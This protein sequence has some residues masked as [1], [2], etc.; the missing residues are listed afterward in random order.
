MISLRYHIV[1]I[2]AV[3]LAIAIGL[4]A[5][6]AFVEP[7][8]VDQLRNQTDNLRDQVR[9]LEGDVT[10]TRAEIDGLDGFVDAALPYLTGDRLFGVQVVVVAQEGVEDALLGQTQRSLADA[11]ATVMAV[12][13]ARGELASEDPATQA[14]LAELL[15]ETAAAPEDLLEMAATALAERLANGDGG[16]GPA[17][18]V[19][20]RLL[21]DG[22]L[23]PVGSGVSE[24]T[25]EQIGSESQ[26]VVVLG[27]GE[28]E[29]PP[30]EAEAFAVPFVQELA[31][32]GV[33]VAAGESATTAVGFV[34]SVAGG[35]G[36]VTVD[37]L[38]LPIGGAALVLGLDR[39]LATG[40][41]GAFG[42]KDGADPLPPIS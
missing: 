28:D 34:G 18:D 42:M 16:A 8:L 38:D 22:F 3:F 10:A 29:E 15:G 40:E 5:G 4:L 12:I 23:A 1:T 7:G 14:R 37:D 11:G 25:L 33:P 32:L 20:A 31:R 41:G 6:S 2:V 17:E 39:L 27:G 36:V 26:V 24:T 13:A 9:E 19:L 30:L 35:D 21:S